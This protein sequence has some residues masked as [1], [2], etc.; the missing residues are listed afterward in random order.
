MHGKDSPQLAFGDFQMDSGNAR[1]TRGSETVALTPKAFDTLHYLAQRPDELVTKEQLLKAI[2]PD[3]IVGDA[4]V[5]VCIREIRKALEDDVQSPKYIE[6]VHRRG[7]RFISKG[8][9][10]GPAPIA[11]ESTT[12]VG[13]D[14]ELKWLLQRFEKAQGGAR[15]MVFITGRPGSGK[16]ALIDALAQSL[17]ASALVAT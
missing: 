15:Q 10:A 2:W 12:L 13:R 4:S 8:G 1:L 5:K 7:Y 16:T 14:E 3:V 11:V 9:S 17:Q 6:T